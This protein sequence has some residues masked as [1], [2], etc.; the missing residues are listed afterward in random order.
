MCCKEK[1]KGLKTLHYFTNVLLRNAQCYIYIYSIGRWFQ[2]HYPKWLANVRLKKLSTE[3]QLLYIRAAFL[4]P[5][6]Q[7]I[8]DLLLLFMGCVFITKRSVFWSSKIENIEGVARL[9]PWCNMKS[10]FPTLQHCST[11]SA[12]FDQVEIDIR[13]LG[14]AHAACCSVLSKCVSALW[15]SRLPRTHSSLSVL[16]FLWRNKDM[17]IS[18]RHSHTHISGL[19]FTETESS[20]LKKKHEETW[21]KWT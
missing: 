14:S 3:P 15:L 2:I 1:K 8:L 16:L 13:E 17:R 10:H 7:P 20:P 18:E 9:C 12:V 6:C 11:T 19:G 4:L 21:R 5:Y